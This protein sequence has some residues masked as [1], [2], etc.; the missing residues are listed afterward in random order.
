[1]PGW[2]KALIAAGI[3]AVLIVNGIAWH[4]PEVGTFHDDGVYLV[5]AKALAE[6]KGYRIESLP[7]EIPQTK[8]P[9]LFPLMLAAAWKLWP[10]FPQNV[11]LLKLV[12]LGCSLAWFWLTWLLLRK[13]GAPALVAWA[14]V[15]TA[16]AAPWAVYFSTALLSETL[17]AAL[18][19]GCLLLLHRPPEDRRALYLAAVL[20]G[21][22]FLTRSIG[23]ALLVAGPVWLAWQRRW[24]DALRFAIIGGLLAAPWWVWTAT[25]PPSA[26]PVDAYYSKENY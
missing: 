18:V 10:Q 17:F 5:T 13:D 11:W 26:S 14:V 21:C 2:A 9:I 19:T 25:R 22:A 20:A 7:N 12:P 23:L 3:L 24:V 16:A 8:Y 4:A 15:L 6:G 1:V